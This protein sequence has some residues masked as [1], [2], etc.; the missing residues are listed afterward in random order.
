MN[1]EWI[2]VKD[3]VRFRRIELGLSVGDLA[4]A[5]G[6]RTAE[7]VSMIESGHRPIDPH[8]APIFAEALKLD[9][10]GFCLCVLFEGYPTFYHAVFGAEEPSRPRPLGQ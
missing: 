9:T 6:I 10:L 5:V 8:R 3:I 2:P 1:W 4:Q 7:F